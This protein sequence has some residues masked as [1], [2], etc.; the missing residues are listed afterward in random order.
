MTYPDLSD[1]LREQLDS[2][3]SIY[4]PDWQREMRPC[5]VTLKNGDMLPRV[6]FVEASELKYVAKWPTKS[7]D[8]LLVTADEIAAIADSPVRTP[9]RI[10]NQLYEWGESGMG[11]TVFTLQFNDRSEQVYVVGQKYD[12]LQYPPGKSPADINEVFPGKGRDRRDDPS[13]LGSVLD[14]NECIYGTAESNLWS[15]EYK[16]ESICTAT[17]PDLKYMISRKTDWPV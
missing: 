12:F 4:A 3:P 14:V 9:A 2:V 16:G 11:W 10:A 6:Y 17:Q 13:T 15:L 8:P 1:Q 5:S 7:D